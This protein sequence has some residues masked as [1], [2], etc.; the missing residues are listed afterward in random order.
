MIYAYICMQT[1][2]CTCQYAPC[3]QHKYR[4]PRCL[5]VSWCTFSPS[6][7]ERHSSRFRCV[8]EILRF[9]FTSL[10]IQ[11]MYVCTCI[12]TRVARPISFDE[13]RTSRTR[14]WF[15]NK[16]KKNK[17]NRN[18]KKTVGEHLHISRP[19]FEQC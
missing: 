13:R 7:V 17:E 6:P 1:C 12:H 5:C 14:H 2:T 8:Y 10:Y 3:C 19:E 16:K 9:T 18:K 15:P 4:E 11:R